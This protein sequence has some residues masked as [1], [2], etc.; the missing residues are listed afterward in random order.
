M[1]GILSEGSAPAVQDG[2]DTDPCAEAPGISGDGE[3]RLGR[4]L[5]QQV[6]DHALV[7]VGDVA[8]FA[9]QRVHDVKVRHKC[10][11]EHLCRYVLSPFMCCSA[12]NRRAV[13][14][15][16]RASKNINFFG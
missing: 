9:R 8:Q 16:L 5:N 13:Q 3:R 7:L 12:Q 11:A 1:P 2:R 10:S 4:R 15:L 14:R 6:V